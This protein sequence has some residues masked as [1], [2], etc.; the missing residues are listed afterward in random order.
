VT[1]SLESKVESSE[2]YDNQSQHSEILQKAFS[3][4]G[5]NLYWVTQFGTL[6]P[7]LEAKI[8]VYGDKMERAASGVTDAN[9]IARTSV[10][11]NVLGAIV[12][13]GEDS[14]IVS[15][16]IDKFQWASPAHSAERTYIY[17]DRPIYRPGQEVFMKGLYRIGYDGNYEIF[18]DKKAD[19]EVFNSKGESVFKQSLDINDY[20]TFTANFILDTRAPLGTYRI[21]GLG[22]HAYFDVEEYSPATFKLDVSSP[23]DEYIAG[24]FLD[25][26]V[27][28]N[29]Y[30]GV[31]LEGGDVEYSILA[32]DY[33]FD[34]YEDGY[35]QF[36]SGWY[37]S[38]NGGYGDK[39]ILRGKEKLDDK[40]KAKIE[41]QLD[42]NKF[43]KEDE[44]G[45]SKI[46]VVNV[47]VKNT[48]R[49]SVS[50]QKSFIVHRGEIYLGVNLKDRYFAKGTPNKLL[51]KSVDTKG[52]DVSVGNIE[53]EINKI[54]WESFKRQEVDGNYYYQRK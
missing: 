38:Y 45:K 54:K 35:F 19:V 3:E 20:G 10:A 49:Q 15:S 9:G 28:A 22:G 32:Q 21:S 40:G 6:A 41:K 23:K 7:V 44:R 18:R 36:G 30:F 12:T 14:T 25:L 5:G 47:T 11:S 50:S 31:P 13:K 53:V 46:F 48:T 27:D 26:N 1:L 37:Y 51:V 29:Y 17:T 43:F 8:D 24:D 2:Y 16:Q 52:K 33:N 39:F 34:R 4:S 42:F